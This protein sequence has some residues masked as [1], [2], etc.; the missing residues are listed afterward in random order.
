MLHKRLNIPSR[1]LCLSFASWS[2]PVS[3]LRFSPDTAGEVLLRSR[4]SSST[5]EGTVYE[6]TPPS[7][8]PSWNRS[9]R[10]GLQCSGQLTRVQTRWWG[11]AC[12]CLLCNSILFLLGI[13]NIMQIHMAAI[14]PC[15]SPKLSFSYSH[16]HTHRV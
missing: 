2:I 8:D 14:I 5:T 13:I 11:Q 7:N 16:I 1:Y 9:V 4:I 12:K 15:L 10:S 6:L 3:P